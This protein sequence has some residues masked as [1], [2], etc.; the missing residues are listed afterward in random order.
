MNKL[1]IQAINKHQQN[2]QDKIEHSTIKIL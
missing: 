2:M 1:R